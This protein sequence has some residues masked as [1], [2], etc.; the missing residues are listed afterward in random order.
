MEIK[1]FSFESFSYMA[2]VANL[3]S[4]GSD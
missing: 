4:T 3:S 2:G 1:I